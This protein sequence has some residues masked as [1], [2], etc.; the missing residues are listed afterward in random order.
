[1]TGFGGTELAAEDIPGVGPSAEAAVRNHRGPLSN[2]PQIVGG[3]LQRNERPPLNY[4]QRGALTREG[5]AGVAHGD[6][7]N[8]G[9]AD[10][11]IRNG[12]R[13]VGSICDGHTIVRPL[14]TQW[15]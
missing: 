3:R 10:L 1:M 6:L 12:Y 15:C 4:C 11:G 8:A 7:I 5:T 2:V 14:I 9:I 13:G